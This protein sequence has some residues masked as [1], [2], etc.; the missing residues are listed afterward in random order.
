MLIPQT[1][2]AIHKA[3][4]YRLLTKLADDAELMNDLCFKGGTCA[5]MLDYLDRFSIDLDFDYIGEKKS[6]AKTR[7][8]LTKHFI[9]LELE[10]KDF[11]KSGIQYFLKYPSESSQRNTLKLEASFPP[12]QS[13]E[14]KREYFFDI[15]RTIPCQTIETMFANKL[16]AILDRY[17]KHHSLAGR[18]LYDIH[19]FFLKGFRYKIEVIEERRNVSLYVFFQELVS[20]VEKKFTETNIREDISTLLPTEKFQKIRKILKQEILMLLRD[21]LERIQ[22]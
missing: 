15:D 9:D 11:S 21:E 14:Y 12:P 5:S 13:N 3:W 6:V 17:E 16:V 4:L 8:Q 20:F 22:P 7:K 10:I 1:K 18:D 2:D 19:Y